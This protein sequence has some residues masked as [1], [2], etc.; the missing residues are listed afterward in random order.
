MAEYYSFLEH[1]PF[2]LPIAWLIRGFGGVFGHKGAYK[3]KMIHEID[4]QKI[5]VV[6]EL[7]R[8]MNFEFHK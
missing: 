6:Q 5:G 2:L 7:Y 1:Y 4:K 3:R 8:E